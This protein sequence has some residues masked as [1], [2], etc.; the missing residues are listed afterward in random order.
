MNLSECLGTADIS[1]LRAI[2]ERYRL[3][4]S[5]HSKL[6][7]LQ[8]ILYAFRNPAF[9]AEQVPQWFA[10]R[11][12]ALMRLSLEPRN[13]FSAEE[14]TGAFQVCGGEQ[15]VQDALGQGW[16]FPTTRL[17]GRRLYCIPAELQHVMRRHVVEQFTRQ[18]RTST[19][20]PLTYQEEG[21]AMVRDLSVM[22]EYIHHHNVQL[23]T[24]GS[25]YKRNLTQL[26]Q[27]LEVSEAPLQGGWR[28]GYGRRFHD[29]PDRLALL[30]DYAYSA[31]WIFE[32]DDGYLHTADDLTS[33]YSLTPLQQ[34][35]GLVKFYLQLYRR[36]IQRLPLVVNLLAHTAQT[37]V[38]SA[39]MLAALADLVPS[40]YYDSREQVWQTRILKMLMHLGVLRLGQD[41]NG[42]QWFQITQLGQQLITSDALPATPEQARERQRILMVQPNFEIVVTG[43]QPAVTAELAA[44]C[45][46]RQAGAIRVYRM[47][48]VSVAKGVRAGKPLTGWLEFLHRYAQTPVPG[49]VE[50]AL[51]EWERAMTAGKGESEPLTS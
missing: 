34:L 9:L 7:L 31:Q 48:E 17:G 35:R 15:A 41:E 40:Y 10:G 26:L 42:Q 30:Y 46:L 43:D 39:G 19:E 12:A 28:F 8:E 36:P 3:P 38:D 49:N 24:S 23:T 50:R 1:T 25:M 5:K 32:G 37:W 11:E 22:L 6:S 16:L 51:Q 14:L 21:Y 27:L 47:T 29:Y 2:A 20:G 45:E 4:C 13:R 44:F 18:V 33:W